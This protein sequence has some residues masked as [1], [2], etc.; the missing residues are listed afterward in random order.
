M[1][2][3]KAKTKR[4]WDIAFKEEG[5]KEIAGSRH[6]PRIM[7]MAREAGFTNYT[8]DEI[9][10]CAM[11]ANYVVQKAGL[12][13]TGK[14]TARSFENWGVEVPLRDAPRGAV[15]VFWRVR[16]DG[17][18]GHVAFLDRIENGKIYVLGGNQ[19]NS[20]NIA[21][22]AWDRFLTARVPAKPSRKTRTGFPL[23]GTGK[24]LSPNAVAAMA[25][26][27]N[28]PLAHLKA[29]LDVEAAGSGF[30]AG[31]LLKIL[32]EPHVLYRNVPAGNAR[33]RLERVGLAYPKW[34]TRRYP[35]T[36][37]ARHDQ[38]ATAHGVVGDT[39]Y[40]AISSGI[41][42]VLHENAVDLGY[43]TAA[44]MTTEMLKGEVA[45]LD[46][47]M[48]FIRKNNILG[49]L[50][51][52]KWST[53]AR[54]YNGPGYAKNRY[55]TKLA[56]AAR[57]HR[58]GG[59]VQT[60]Q[61]PSVSR[62]SVREAQTMLTALGYDPGVIDGWMGPN[63]ANAVL[64]FQRA[65]PDL[66]NDG[67][68]GPHTFAA[69][70]EAA[71]A[72]RNKTASESTVLVGGGGAAAVAAWAGLPWW[73]YALIALATVGALAGVVW[74]LAQRYPDETERL[75]NAAL[76]ATVKVRAWAERLPEKL[77]KEHFS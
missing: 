6:N 58:E 42:Q 24:R 3:D 75:R 67:E 71:E 20:V 60:T 51:T 76:G 47:V 40:V 53:F 35:R 44:A 13:G 26:D 39:S 46:A 52:G 48:R 17:W 56:A 55:H 57:V 49:A 66:M 29:V 18:Q 4:L 2:I 77:L 30:S 27:Y 25:R 41:G 23:I 74:W 54:R 14:L 22:Y 19:S 32:F 21:P 31:N 28:V 43:G 64:A 34:G 63:T 9:A 70:Q 69:L 10:W 72:K 15:I 38:L 1:E 62:A 7:E 12:P 68:L 37:A 50:R 45:Q 5:V 33:R 73:T 16:R 65:H 61:A 59:P 8:A 36:M 11:F